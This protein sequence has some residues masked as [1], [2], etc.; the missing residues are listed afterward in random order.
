MDKDEIHQYYNNKLKLVKIFRLNK[1]IKQLQ[2]EDSL[3]KKI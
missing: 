3:R 2:F 1:E